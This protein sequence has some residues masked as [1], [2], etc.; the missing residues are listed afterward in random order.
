MYLGHRGEWLTQST[1]ID[2]NRQS[3][4]ARAVHAGTS[5]VKYNV[6]TDCITHTD[7]SILYFFLGD[8]HEHTDLENAQSS[9]NWIGPIQ[10]FSAETDRRFSTGPVLTVWRGGEGVNKSRFRVTCSLLAAAA[11]TALHIA[12]LQ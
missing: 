7:V 2:V 11:A 6:S 10:Y 8:I 12:L 1:A 4:I 5:T 9:Q 3:G